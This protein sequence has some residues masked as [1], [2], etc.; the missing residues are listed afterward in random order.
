MI[1]VCGG[2]NI[3]YGVIRFQFVYI[4]FLLNGEKKRRHTRHNHP[5]PH[6]TDE[7]FMEA[8]KLYLFDFIFTTCLMQR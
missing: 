5:H 6:I 1:G 2:I 3:A 8:Y 7:I 4:R